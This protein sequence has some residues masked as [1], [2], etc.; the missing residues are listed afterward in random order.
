MI[1]RGRL[2]ERRRYDPDFGR[3][4]IG[5][6]PQRL[7]TPLRS[8]QTAPLEDLDPVSS[9]A[10]RHFIRA[11]ST[12]SDLPVAVSLRSFAQLDVSGDRP[13]VLDLVRALLAQL[14]AFHSPDDLRVGL[15]LAVDRQPDWEWAKWLPH[16]QA[17]PTKEDAAPTR[18][19]P[20]GWSPTTSPRWPT[21]SDRT[22]ATDRCSASP[23]RSASTTGTWWSSW[24]A[25]TSPATP[26]WCPAAAATR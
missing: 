7:A 16:A 8:P 19:A 23:P 5:T 26:S 10:L 2:W 4:R 18:R 13:A 9:T 17:T 14:A 1:E 25:A 12:V 11:Y 6:G 15:C 21:C 3:V 20:R 22:S 24:T